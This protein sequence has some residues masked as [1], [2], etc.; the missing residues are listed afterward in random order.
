MWIAPWLGWAEGWAE[1]ANSTG[2]VRRRHGG[3]QTDPRHPPTQPNCVE[4]VRLGLNR[5]EGPLEASDFDRSSDNIDRTLLIWLLKEDLIGMPPPPRCKS[6]FRPPYPIHPPCLST[7]H[8]PGPR[9]LSLSIPMPTSFLA[10]HSATYTLIPT[11][12]PT[13]SS[14][15]TVV[16]TYVHTYPYLCPALCCAFTTTTVSA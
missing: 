1:W 6:Q 3:L 2:P 10:T 8:T 5:C 14:T 11:A 12:T 13:S 7:I 15:R 4:W 9:H 16:P